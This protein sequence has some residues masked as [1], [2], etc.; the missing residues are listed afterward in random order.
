LIKI[1]KLEKNKKKHFNLLFLTQGVSMEPTSLSRHT[2]MTLPERNSHGSLNSRSSS[3][4]LK[5]GDEPTKMTLHVPSP[6]RSRSDHLFERLPGV[7][8]KRGWTCS[9]FL[10]DGEVEGRFS[11]IFCPRDTAI[12]Y[13]GQNLHANRIHID[14]DDLGFPGKPPCLIAAQAPTMGACGAFWGTLYDTGSAIIDLRTEKDIKDVTGVYYPQEI[15]GKGVTYGDFQV[16]LVQQEGLVSVYQVAPH[17][18]WDSVHTITRYHFPGW[19]DK[20]AVT[21]DIL[22]K[23]IQVMEEMGDSILVHCNAG[24]GRTGTVLTAFFLKAFIRGNID[25]LLKEDDACAYV[26]NY[27]VY[28]IAHLRQQRGPKCVQTPDQFHLL[29]CYV[30]FLINRHMAQQSQKMLESGK[31]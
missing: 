28:V 27:L 18:N 11:D 23:M 30:S 15:G 13:N 19:V 21:E 25:R 2:G 29:R 6:E 24:V 31:A 1:K 20:A 12:A 5:S 16:V 9:D 4:S 3:E 14:F 7:A 17:G 22:D 10:S 8:E 26:D